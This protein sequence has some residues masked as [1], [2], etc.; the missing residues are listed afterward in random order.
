MPRLSIRD[1]Y[2]AALDA[3]FTPHQATTWTA[4]ALAESSGR[5]DALNA[6]G[7]H[8]MGLWQI[9]VDPDVRSN[10]WGD[11]TDPGVNAQ[12]AFDISNGGTDMRP[13]TT[14][15]A[16]NAGTAAD[17]RTYLPDVEAVTGV[18]GDPRGV[19]DFKSS[20][21]PPLEGPEFDAHPPDEKY[22]EIDVV[23]PPGAQQDTDADGLTDAY[24]ELLGTSVTEADSDADG[25]SDAYELGRLRSDPLLADTD[26]DTLS[27]SD[28]AAL[29]TSAR[30]WDSDQDGIS[31]RVE[32][33]YGTDPLQPDAGEGVAPVEPQPEP[34]SSEP[35]PDSQVVGLETAQVDASGIGGGPGLTSTVVLPVRGS[36]SAE[37]GLPGDWAAGHHTG[38]DFAVDTGTDVLSP[39]DGVVISAAYEGDYGETI[40]I[41]NVDGTITLLAHLSDYEVTPG[42]EVSAGDVVGYSGNTGRSTGPHLHWEIRN[43]DVYADTQDPM[44]WVSEYQDVA[45]SVQQTMG[46]EVPDLAAAGPEPAVH[47]DEMDLGTPVAAPVDSDQDGLSDRFEELAGMDTQSADTDM[48]GLDDAYEAVVSHTDPLSA[49]TDSDL[50]SDADEIAVGT[51]AGSIPGI[52]GVAGHGEFAELIREGAPDADMDGLSDQYEARLGLNPEAADTDMD[53]LLDSDEVALGTDATMLDSD[54]DGFGDAFEVEFGTNPLEPELGGNDLADLADAGADSGVDAGGDDVSAGVDIDA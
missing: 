51:D 37:Y 44:N 26:Q 38:T 52:A 34:Q 27:D 35:T 49:D 53:G 14:T 33:R 31:D 8:S 54:A 3:G 30:A 40:K 46:E 47:Y 48:D 19:E 16:H 5:T 20:L 10:V 41:R 23:P 45:G 9:N 39:M 4:I 11:L 28:E 6:V 21:P 25:L 24:E 18:K 29:G 50:V 32:V 42:Q 13:W 15:H 36:I 43:S 2:E 17:Y 22:D 1:I 12:A 7:E